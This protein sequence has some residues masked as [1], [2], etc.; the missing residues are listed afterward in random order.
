MYKPFCPRL[1]EA[2]DLLPA[3]RHHLV[4]AAYR[5][6]LSAGAAFD[7]LPI[8][9]DGLFGYE[10]LPNRKTARYFMIACNR[11][12]TPVLRSTDYGGESPSALR[13]ASLNG[14]LLTSGKASCSRAPLNAP[15]P[16]GRRLSMQ[17]G[18]N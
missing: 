12:G 8:A 6:P 5:F 3:L 10:V 9:E 13:L 1:S 15:T 2:C 18:R 11:R 17:R 14:R 7:L 4:S 16:I